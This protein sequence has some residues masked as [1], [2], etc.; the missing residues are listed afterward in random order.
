M[1]DS[2]EEDPLPDVEKK[3]SFQAN[4]NTKQLSVSADF[5]QMKT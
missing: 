4:E 1:V 5:T 2:V 3:G